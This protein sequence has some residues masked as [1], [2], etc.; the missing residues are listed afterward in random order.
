MPEDVVKR[1]ATICVDMESSSEEDS[2]E[3]LTEEITLVMKSLTEGESVIVLAVE[4]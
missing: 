3:V 4:S 2:E 1:G